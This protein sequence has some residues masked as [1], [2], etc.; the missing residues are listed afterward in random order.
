MLVPEGEQTSSDD[1]TLDDEDL[2]EK[3]KQ[4]REM[5]AEEDRIKSEEISK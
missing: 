5:M 2:F 3:F 4:F 1:D